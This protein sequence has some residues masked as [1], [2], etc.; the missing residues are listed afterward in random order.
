MKPSALLGAQ[1][2]SLPQLF[3]CFVPVHQF[4]SF[5][6]SEAMLDLGSDIVAI[7][8]EPLLLLMEHLD[9]VGDEFIGGL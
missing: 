1:F 3:K 2:M 7:V 6:L 9:G 5:R 8:S 4:A